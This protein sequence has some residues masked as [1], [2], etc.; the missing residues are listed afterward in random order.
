MAT[1]QKNVVL[2]SFDDATAPWRYKTA[3][4]EPL[5]T[6]NLDRICAQS[7]VF[8]SAYCQAPICGPSRAS[9]MSAKTPHQLGI[10]GNSEEL[11]DKITPQEVWSYKLKEAGFFCSSGGKVHHRYKPLRRRFHNVIYSD[12]QKRFRDDM[13]FPDVSE[14]KRYGGNRGGWASVDPKDDDLFYDANSGNS[15]IEFFEGYD[16][17]AP[18][19]REVGF[20][21]PHGPH[22]TPARFKD[23]YD[24]DNF[25]PPEDWANGFD[26]NA[27]SDELNAENEQI[28][29]GDMQWWRESVRN[30]FSAFSHGDYHLG[31]VWDAL[32]ASPHAKDTVVVILSDHGFH[33]GNRNLY[34]KTTLYEQVASV[35]MVIYDPDN[36]TGLD[37]HDPVA[38]LDVG[39]TVLDIAGLR[40]LEDCVGQSLLPYLNGHCDPDR[41]VPTFRH[42]NAAIRKGPYRIIRYEDGTTQMYD[43]R[44]D[45]WQLNSLGPDHPDYAEMYAALVECS[46]Q[47]GFEVPAA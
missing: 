23:M 26:F 33:L 20:Y 31:R 1:R 44:D 3:F 9:F 18:F 38:L 41:A 11:F 14:K 30:Y 46:A 32:Q 37:I 27:F 16:R 22:Y 15:A 2:I 19:Y 28:K 6:P 36:P 5:Q 8:H 40:P 39:P 25:K 4:N 43:L 21:S 34:R 45:F 29:K 7:T 10:F 12:N 42:G 24:V 35:P 17:D 13:H 47:Y